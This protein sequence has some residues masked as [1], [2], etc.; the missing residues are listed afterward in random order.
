MTGHCHNLYS[1]SS[2]VVAPDVVLNCPRASVRRPS[3]PAM[4]GHCGSV[5][6][7]HLPGLHSVIAPVRSTTGQ[8]HSYLRYCIW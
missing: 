2:H 1:S 4:M 7:P 8:S 5:V 3:E 6:R